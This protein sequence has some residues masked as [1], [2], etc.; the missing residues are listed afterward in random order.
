MGKAARG[1]E[2]MKG[3]IGHF[4]YLM[5]YAWKNNKGLF[6]IILVKSLFTALIPVVNI[7]GIGIV[8]DALVNKR[9]NSYVVSAIVIYLSVNLGIT[10]IS[11]ILT[12]LDNRSMRKASDILQLDYARDSVCIDYHYAQDGS[13]LNL[14]KRSMISHP[15]WFLYPVGEFFNCI[16]RLLSVIYIFSLLTPVFTL[17]ISLT[18]F[19]SVYVTLKLQALTFKFNND[20]IEDDRILSY[21][22][23]LMS[24]S[25]YFKEI[26][27]NKA[28][29]C[30]EDNYIS[31]EE[32]LVEKYKRYIRKKGLLSVARA[33]VAVI[34]AG[35][36]YFYFSYQFFIKTI[37]L[38]E[39]TVLL[40]A[41]TL[42]S[43]TFISLFNILGKIN[44][45]LNYTDLFIRYRNFIKENSSVY[46]SNKLNMP[47]I[48]SHRFEITF[49]NVSFVYP[50]T[51]KMILK[52]VSFTIKNGEKIGIAG[53][54]GSGKTTLVKLLCRLYDPTHGR[55][56]LNGI[57]IKEIP[58]YQYSKYIGVVLQDFKLFAY[59]V[60]ENIAFNSKLD[61]C[62]LD[63]SLKKSGAD[64]IV[65]KLPLGI[66]TS[67]YKT[68][69]DEGVDLSGGEGQKI[70]IAKSIYKNAE[71]MI[72]DEPTSAL[73]AVAE[74][75]LFSKLSEISENKTTVFISHRLS[76]TKF[77]DRIMV[78]SEGV[79]AE[80]G[81]HEQLMMSNG[82]YK[83]LFE[84]QAK[85]YKTENNNESAD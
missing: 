60:K 46:D 52:N 78:I 68:L 15:A 11:N 77:C 33:T 6:I 22:Y 29:E 1:K 31:A 74:Y 9:G 34:E 66:D 58:Y 18:S 17:I 76:S 57:N 7:S 13:I 61:I 36:M 81:S 24:D 26:R 47:D 85:Y 62:R 73:D 40:G 30:I 44:N 50:N 49:D 42:F 32:A 21:L 82:I 14:K 4:G 70:S 56:L 63:E 16:V 72:L 54:N 23:T 59:S 20:K 45:T 64:G 5:S 71:I 8:V 35:F 80:M 65:E 38:G 83:D 55:I 41:V 19:L 75:E 79:I 69:D 10:L 43:S 84:S 67:I 48:A 37:T 12:Y 39:Y 28:N 51:E 25:K 3:K 2:K 27:V 53:L